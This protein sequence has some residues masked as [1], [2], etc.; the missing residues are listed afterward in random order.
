MFLRKISFGGKTKGYRAGAT[1]PQ[2]D[3]EHL[4]T[5]LTS[6]NFTIMKIY[7]MANKETRVSSWSNRVEIDGITTSFSYEKLLKVAEENLSDHDEEWQVDLKKLTAIREDETSTTKQE[8][9]I[10]TIEL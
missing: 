8:I 10:K 7:I 1:Y 6:K 3:T 4:T 2:R 9:I 5:L